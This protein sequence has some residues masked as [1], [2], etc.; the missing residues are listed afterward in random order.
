MPTRMLLIGVGQA[1]CTKLGSNGP[2]STSC[3]SSA[4]SS[5]RPRNS[6]AS[7]KGATT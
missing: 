7:Q 4:I 6:G 3:V 1:A 2:R 5:A